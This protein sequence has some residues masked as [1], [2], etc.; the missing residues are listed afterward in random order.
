MDSST[1]TIICCLP[2]TLVGQW[3]GSIQRFWVPA[4]LY[5]GRCPKRCLP[6]YATMPATC[7]LLFKN[8]ISM[9]HNLRWQAFI[10][11]LV[12]QGFCWRNILLTVTARAGASS[13][14][15]PSVLYTFPHRH[16]RGP[17]VRVICYFFQDRELDWKW[18]QSSK[19]HPCRMLALQLVVSP[20]TVQHRPRLKIPWCLFLSSCFG[21]FFVIF[22][23]ASFLHLLLLCSS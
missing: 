4:T 17:C 6:H 13:S 8:N 2:E 18:R 23:N 16:S 12:L 21:E 22:F 19:G 7:S 20:S 3:V 1:W 10:F 15:H 9:D 11:L 14:Q 5:G